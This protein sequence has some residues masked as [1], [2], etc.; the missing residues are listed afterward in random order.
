MD[1]TT[2]YASQTVNGCESP[3]RT[4]V[5]VILN[6]RLPAPEGSATQDFE[7][8][9]TIA[10]LV[11]T[12]ANV[13]WYASYDDAVNNTNPLSPTTQLVDGT[14]YYAVAIADG[15]CSSLPLA[16]TA[17]A[18]LGVGKPQKA[19][20]KYYPNP[21]EN[22]LNIQ[23]SAIIERIEVYSMLGQMVKNQNCHSGEVRLFLGDLPD[24]TYVVSIMSEGQKSTVKVVKK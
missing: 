5:I 20:F 17:N 7:E 23:S 19:T 8:G 15:Q 3:E 14:T 4:L 18:A 24:G 16:V 1:G 11:V 12:P 9:A 2:Y 13:I 22:Y 21:V 10:D 6:D